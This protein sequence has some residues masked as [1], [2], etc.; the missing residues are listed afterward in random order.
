MN[1]RPQDGTDVPWRVIASYEGG[2]VYLHDSVQVF[3][4]RA[5]GGVVVT[6][7]HMGTPA[8]LFGASTGAKALMGNDAGGGRD[9]AGTS[10]LEALEQYDV[11]A[12]AVSHDSARI[13]DGPDTYDH[14]VVSRANRWAAEVGVEPGMA[15]AEAARLMASWQPRTDRQRPAADAGHHTT[16][17]R[18][19]APRV[20]AVDSASQIVPGLDEVIVFT[21]SHGGAVGGVGVRHPVAAAVFNDAGGG[22]DGAGM[23]RL[24]LLDDMGIPAATVSSSSARIGFGDETYERGV[25]SAVNGSAEALGITVGMTARQAA[26]ILVRAVKGRGNRVL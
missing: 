12:V 11:A 18:S 25:L 2:D 15:A 22:K 6:G 14:G 9:S 24:P 19:A 21:G 17:Y 8:C 4:E 7:S 5:E 3:D 20:I 16:V 23:S 26:D 13:G 10:G 1:H